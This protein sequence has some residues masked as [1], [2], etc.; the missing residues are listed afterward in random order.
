M[1]AC[2]IE[3]CCL[4]IRARSEIAFLKRKKIPLSFSRETK[5]FKAPNLKRYSHADPGEKT[6][7]PAAA[8]TAD[9]KTVS[10]PL[11]LATSSNPK[12]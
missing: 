12:V 4:A 5:L 2:Q 10:V 1:I 6:V 9:T 11:F 8:F 7:P 3:L